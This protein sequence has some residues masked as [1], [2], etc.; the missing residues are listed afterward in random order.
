[1]RTFAVKGPTMPKLHPV[2]NEEQEKAYCGP[3]VL[4]AITNRP[5]KVVKECIWSSRGEHKPGD[6][7]RNIPKRS[8]IR[9]TGEWD[10]SYVLQRLAG[11]R[12]KSCRCID[13]P[14]L[15]GWLKARTPD[16]RQRTFILNVSF[17]KS[18]GL[19]GPKSDRGH[20]VAVRGNTFVDTF[21]S[22]QLV[23]TSKAPHRRKR[24]TQVLEVVGR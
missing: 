23:A 10:L 5:V 16:E 8:V 9:G 6:I 12:L 13:K 15:A 7:D 20:W 4:A 17:G 21:T 11:Y 3:T 1:M 24:V 14:T 2:R 18:G 19:F 22:G